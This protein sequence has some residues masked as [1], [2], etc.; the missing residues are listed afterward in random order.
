MKK[1]YEC[2]DCEGHGGDRG[3]VDIEDYCPCPT[4]EGNGKLAQETKSW[5]QKLMETKE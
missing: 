5:I 2:P 4:C 1:D 3:I